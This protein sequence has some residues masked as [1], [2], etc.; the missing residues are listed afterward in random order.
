MGRGRG[1]VRKGRWGGREQQEEGDGKGGKR[2]GE[3]QGQEE[4]GFTD[5][6]DEMPEWNEVV[7]F[8]VYLC[9]AGYP[10]CP[11][12]IPFLRHGSQHYLGSTQTHHMLYVCTIYGYTRA[13]SHPLPVIQ[14]ILCSCIT[15]ITI[16]HM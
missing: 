11:I 1:A 9:N 12:Y 5:G 8:S 15:L 6:C 2:A 16:Y 4:S 10:S 13:K 7:E 3:K 14:P